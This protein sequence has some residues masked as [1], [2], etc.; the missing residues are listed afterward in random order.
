MLVSDM[1]KN[2]D[3]LQFGLDFS[4]KCPSPQLFP[5]F[6]W[7]NWAL[8]HFERKDQSIMSPTQ[9]VS[10]MPL[11][12]ALQQLYPRLAFAEL[13]WLYDRL[14]KAGLP[15]NPLALF[16]FYQFRFDPR[17]EKVLDLYLELPPAFQ[18][19]AAQHDMSPRDLNPLITL[20]QVSLLNDF[21]QVIYENNLTRSQAAQ[22]LELA[23]ELVLLDNPW[24]ELAP[25]EDKK[26]NW[27]DYWLIHLRERRYPVT[28]QKDNEEKNKLSD[29]PWSKEFSTKWSR[30]GD[31]S[32]L[33][34]KFMLTSK[35]DLE[36]KL[37]T[38]QRIHESWSE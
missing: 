30:T 14:K 25:P 12:A 22:I 19:W 2:T 21:Y 37:Q 4:P 34:V 17:L 38:L 27:V 18:T 23:V 29:L 10:H 35:A 31:K 11:Q 1:L 36:K 3:T 24:E 16:S 28:L 9:D 13:A 20:P 5:I 26:P 8:N 32:G 33:E 15:F 6:T 7:N